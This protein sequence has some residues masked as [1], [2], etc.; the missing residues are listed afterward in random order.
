MKYLIYGLA[1]LFT[2]YSA[3]AAHSVVNLTISAKDVNYTGV[4]R[5][6]IA[7]NDQIPGPILHFKEGDQVTIHV[8]N[9]LKQGTTIHWHGVLVP[10]QM[11][12]VDGVSQ[13]AIPPNSTFDYQFTLHQAGTYWYHAHTGL[14]E[15]EGLYGAF[16]IDPRQPSSYRYQE[17]KVIILSDWSNTPA[18]QIL[19]HLKTA[20]ANKSPATTNPSHAQ[21]MVMSPED[22]SDV[23]YDAYLLNGHPPKN[24]WTSSVK[25]GDTLRLRFIGAAAS[26]IYRVSIP[27]TKLQ[28][29]HVQGNDVKPYFVSDFIIA[30]GET[31]DVLVKITKD[32]PYVIHA[33]S[34]DQR[35][36]AIGVLLSHPQ[37][38]IPSVIQDNVVVK[39]RMQPMNMPMS[40]AA[41]NTVAP[42]G[43]ASQSHLTTGTS[44]QT[45]TA[46]EK[47]NDPNKPITSVIHMR[48]SGRMDGYVWLINGLSEQQAKPILI[49]PGKRYR[50]IFT[51]SSMMDHPMHL[52]GHWFIL[53]NGHGSY[54]P[55]LHT[56]NVPPNATV[57]ADVDADASGQW[58][59][60]C[61]NL[62]HMAAGMARIFRYTTL[63]A[64]ANKTQK[65]E[66]EI[67]SGNY[68]NRPIIRVDTLPIN[69]AL[70]YPSRSNP[71]DN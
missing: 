6:A 17:D 16:I 51:N 43:D 8:H 32:Q 30:P 69:S 28:V 26:T 57:V 64:I 68:I 39:Q 44:Y 47:T 20:K 24:P 56:I 27:D 23:T 4:T 13:L 3:S 19:D 41:E 35:G 45:L 62:Y 9:L 49:Q 50:L 34:I 14:Q 25:V 53:R 63:L 58:F 59:F 18:Q 71:T 46:A 1:L 36:T 67:H 66:K 38:A 52:H 48:L 33:E 22:N 40:A 5:P 11:D 55:L 60:H 10:W 7:V 54:D 12:G 70:I 37:Q 29:V 65:P 61:H 15:Q 42:P 2:T 31:Y 21:Q